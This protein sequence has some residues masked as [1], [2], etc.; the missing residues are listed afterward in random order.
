[1]VR[2]I[3]HTYYF[4]SDKIFNHKIIYPKSVEHS[5][6]ANHYHPYGGQDMERKI[7]HICVSQS[8]IGCIDAT[9]DFQSKNQYLYLHY[10]NYDSSKVYQPSEKIV[11]DRAVTG[12]E[13]ILEPVEMIV[14]TYYKIII[15][16]IN[17]DLIE[18]DYI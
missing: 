11:I 1:M 7:K 15:K 12:E 10:C 3:I 9:L 8:I 18:Y 6:F 2:P 16:E 17:N 5:G 13:W 14:K 4:I